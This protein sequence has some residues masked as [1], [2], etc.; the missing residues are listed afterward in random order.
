MRG[1]SSARASR[2]ATRPLRS[3]KIVAL[4]LRSVEAIDPELRDRRAGKEDRKERGEPP[5]RAAP[6]AETAATAEGK[7]QEARA[8][9]ESGS[10]GSAK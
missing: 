4:D 10:R 7:R 3:A 8:R 1:R 6:V 2:L 9:R 5:G